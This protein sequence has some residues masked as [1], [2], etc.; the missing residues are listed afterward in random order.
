MEQYKEQHQTKKM[1]EEQKP[2]PVPAF[3]PPSEWFG[4][5]NESIID[6]KREEWKEILEEDQKDT[7]VIFFLIRMLIFFYS[8]K[9]LNAVVVEKTAF[10]VTFVCLSR[11]FVIG[12]TCGVNRRCFPRSIDILSQNKTCFYNEFFCLSRERNSK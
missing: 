3:D 2:E 6:E 1:E 7:T 4:D 8:P 12:V 9:D 10:R 11:L 5:L